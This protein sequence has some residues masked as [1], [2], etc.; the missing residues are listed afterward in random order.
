M[1]EVY[2]AFFGKMADL[3]NDKRYMEEQRNQIKEVI[4]TLKILEASLD[5][6]NPDYKDLQK[7]YAFRKVSE[8]KGQITIDS[9]RKTTAV[10]ALPYVL[11]LPFAE[12]DKTDIRALI[13]MYVKQYDKYENLI[14]LRE[15][16]ITHYNNI[17]KNTFKNESEFK[18]MEEFKD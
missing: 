17:L 11:E 16:Q 6:A 14:T 1:G 4:W 2:Q 8:V 15:N 3:S 18:G 10:D 9:T 12:L 7:Q 13:N 5:S